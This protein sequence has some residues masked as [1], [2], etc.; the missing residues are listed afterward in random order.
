MV[1]STLH[2]ND[3]LGAIARLEDMGVE[4]FMIASAVVAVLAQRLVRRVCPDCAATVALAV[5][6]REQ[7]AQELGV[8]AALIAPTYRRGSGCKTCG[9][10]GYR[11]RIG[12]Y[13]YVFIDDPIRRAISRGDDL[14]QAVKA[15]YGPEG[16]PSLRRDGIEKVRRGITTYE[17][18]LRVTR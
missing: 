3:A 9:G 18:V 11:G 2:T 15:A 13:E 14:A 5:A 6:E 8:S 4:R 10:T 17:E 7:L 1:F 16:M 12:I